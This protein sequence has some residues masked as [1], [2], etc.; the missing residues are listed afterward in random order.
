MLLNPGG[1]QVQ[2]KK[3]VKFLI[4]R[5]IVNLAGKLDF[6]GTQFHYLIEERSHSGEDIPGDRQDIAKVKEVRRTWRAGWGEW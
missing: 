5:L 3:G 4:E 1:E 2:N 6:R